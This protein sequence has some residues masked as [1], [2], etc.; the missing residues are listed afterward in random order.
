M[1]RQLKALWLTLWF[2]II[3]IAALMSSS[4]WGKLLSLEKQTIAHNHLLS[5]LPSAVLLVIS[6]FILN[7]IGDA[8]RYLNPSPSN[9]EMRRRTRAEGIRL[10]RQLHDCK[11]YD[12]IILVG[13]SLGTVIA[14]DILKNLWPEYNTRHAE[15]KEI[16]QKTLHHLEEI[17]KAL[18]ANPTADL[19]EEFRKQ[20]IALWGELRELGNPW[21]VTDLITMG[22]PLAHAE[23]LLA[24]SKKELCDRQTE[25]EL[26]TCPP[27]PDEGMYSYRLTYVVEEEKRTIFALH[28][29][30]VFACTRWT[31]L[32][33]PAG[34]GFFG[35]LVGGPLSAIFGF[36][37]RDI[38]VDSSELGGWLKH[39]P[40]IH[41]HYW[42]RNTVPPDPKAAPKVWA[43]EALRRALDLESRKW[44]RESGG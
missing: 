42:N 9:I 1:P 22:C 6:T 17:G 32:F 7:Y 20:Q 24:R 11:R 34:L 37:V 12:R 29:A 10:L 2:L 38:P 16:D 36:G 30:A 27:V 23:L 40:V 41:T 4:Y 21:L 14:Y 3:A 39:F 19:A 15:L 13:H 8:A 43:L 28:H 31:N 35:D 5:L 25:R 33:F 44:L 26:P 18:Q